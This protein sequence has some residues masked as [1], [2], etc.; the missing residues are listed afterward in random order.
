[1]GRTRI[2]CLFLTIVVAGWIAALAGTPGGDIVGTWRYDKPCIDARG[3]TFIG[4]LG[5]PIAKKKLAKKINKAFKK[6]KLDKRWESF[7]LSDDGTWEIVVARQPLRGTYTY[8]PELEILTL[9]PR[10]LPLPIKSHTWRKDDRLCVAF[11]ADRLLAVLN[12]LGGLTRS[13]KLK[14]L[15]TLV[16][17][18][19]N[20][21][22]G[23]EFKRVDTGTEL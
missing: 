3:T 19:D 10:H 11:D 6:I 16:D 15:E 23:F 18:F 8:D 22:V 17:N 12:L 13:D 7:T 20:V 5:K 21:H 1:M 9:R 4:K 2:F 14:D